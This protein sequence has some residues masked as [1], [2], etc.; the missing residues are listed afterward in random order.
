MKI[1]VIA[2]LGDKRITK[3]MQSFDVW[4]SWKVH[5]VR[6]VLEVECTDEPDY[7]KIL[8]AL[9]ESLAT[10]FDVA[11]IIIPNR[12]RYVNPDVRAVSTGEKWA[13]LEEAIKHE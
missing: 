1:K 9:R 13:T 4:E 8:E 5:S 7:D 2:W 11:A 12:C 3:M 6:H 10:E